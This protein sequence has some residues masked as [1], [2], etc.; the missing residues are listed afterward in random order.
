MADT[1]VQHEAET[2]IVDHGL[3]LLFPGI[4]F[5]GA[6]LELTWGGVFAFD[7]VS[8]DGS[9]VAAISTSAAHTASGNL[10]TAKFQKL[11]TDALYLLHIKSP[12]R[13]MMIFTESSM[14]EYFKK[15]AAEGRFPPEIELH[16]VELPRE[17]YAK[18]LAVRKIA[19]Q[20]TSPRMKINNL[21]NA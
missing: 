5:K 20:E 17:L 1:S 21:A 4:R 12:A 13:R 9:L 8:E 6:K 18:V 3:P 15:A 19:S 7:A 2:W 14:H 11:K 10:A 16:Y